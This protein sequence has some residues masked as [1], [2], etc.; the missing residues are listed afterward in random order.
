MNVTGIHLARMRGD[1]VDARPIKIP[2]L[3][4]SGHG[5]GVAI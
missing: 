2:T 4:S 3:D 1:V 5:P